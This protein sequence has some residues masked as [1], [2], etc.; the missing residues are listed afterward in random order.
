[1][2]PGASWLTSPVSSRN[3]MTMSNQ[4][5]PDDWIAHEH[6][7]KAVTRRS[8]FMRFPGALGLLLAFA[9][10]VLSAGEARL[11]VLQFES[12][13]LKDNPLHDPVARPV[14]VFLPAQ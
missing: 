2:K 4:G 9:P 3:F 5:W 14:L 11:E 6:N 8:W 10:D 13:A 12:R 1:M 7:M